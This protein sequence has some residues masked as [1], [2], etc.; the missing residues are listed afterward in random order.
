MLKKFT[1]KIDIGDTFFF[2]NIFVIFIF[3]HIL[4]KR[5]FFFDLFG[6]LLGNG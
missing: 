1:L 6:L 4:E 5:I 2:D 3:T